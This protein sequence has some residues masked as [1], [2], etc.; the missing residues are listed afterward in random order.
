MSQTNCARPNARLPTS[1][2]YPPLA[3][4]RLWRLPASCSHAHPS[5]SHTLPHAPTH[6]KTDYGLH[7]CPVVP[8]AEENPDTCPI[9]S[10]HGPY[11]D[12]NGCPCACCIGSAS[13]KCL[14]HDELIFTPHGAQIIANTEA[15]MRTAPDVETKS[16]LTLR[17]A[18]EFRKTV[19][20]ILERNPQVR[21][22][23]GGGRE[24][25]TR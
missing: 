14:T 9:G 10:A 8:C 16:A 25:E 6:S 24:K 23:V 21:A 17:A 12:K 22:G 4:T 5:L 7:P 1:G 11:S 20:N 3:P 13:G 19:G 15:A 2:A 18:S